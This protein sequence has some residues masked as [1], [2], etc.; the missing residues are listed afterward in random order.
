MPLVLQEGLPQSALV[1]HTPVGQVPFVPSLRMQTWF[2]GHPG[3]SQ[4]YTGM[5][6]EIHLPLIQARLWGQS[7][8]VKHR[9]LH[10][11]VL[12]SHMKWGIL[13]VTGFAQRPVVHF[14]LV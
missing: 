12:V 6:A 14:G 7:Q 5:K 9:G 3:L 10:S 2:L 13:D 11:P 8:A 1:L 4:Q